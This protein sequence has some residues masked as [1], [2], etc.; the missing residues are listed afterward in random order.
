MS[1]DRT[2]LT[3]PSSAGVALEAHFEPSTFGL[4]TSASTL[5]C[6]PHPLQGG[7]MTSLVTSELFRILPQ[8]GISALRFNFRGVGASTGEHDFG[9]GESD[10]VVNAFSRLVDL[11]PESQTRVVVGWSFGADVSLSTPLNDRLPDSPCDGWIAIAPPLRF[12][13]EPAAAARSGKPVLVILA[14]HDQVRPAEDVARDVEGWPNTRVEVVGGADHFFAGRTK[15]V[16]ELV[17]EFVTRMLSQ[18]E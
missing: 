6:H 8:G 10:D 15:Q 7:N 4:A 13:T 3:I 11:T 17:E 5:L 14:E 9:K 1:E 16:A 18:P 12:G 2:I